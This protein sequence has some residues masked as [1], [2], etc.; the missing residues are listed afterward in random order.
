[1]LN[2]KIYD[3]SSY[4]P[5]ER[6]GTYGG[7][8]GDKEGI[9]IDGEYWIVK[10]PKSTNG[11]VGD[12]PSYTTAPLSEY[13]GSHIYQM[14]GFETHDTLLGIRN[15]KLVVAC[16][17]FC[18]TEGSLREMRTLKNIYNKQL[19]ELLEKSFSSTSSSHLIDIDKMLLV[20]EHNPI[21]QK[22]PEIN[23]RFWDMFIIDILINN[24]DRNNGN[25]GLLLENGQ[26]KLAPV[27]DNGAA[28]SNKMSD[29]KIR[30]LLNDETKIK[31][32]VLNT[33]TLYSHNDKKVNARDIIKLDFVGLKES[34]KRNTPKIQSQMDN[35]QQFISNIPLKFNGISVCSEVRKK[36]YT[37]SM[38]LRLENFLIP[39]FE[40]A[41]EQANEK[42]S[43]IA[44]V[45]K[46]KAEQKNDPQKSFP[47]KSRNNNV[48]IDD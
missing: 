31:N 43:A 1:M 26:Y 18:K 48:D 46:I 27:F 24:N 2:T 15:D 13:I 14:L 12:L 22:V 20:M 30:I 39:A 23:D 4:E 7:Q 3:L 28:F 38:K 17:D 21:L 6:T 9:T 11:M 33:T 40:K 25:W 44:A 34:V 36:F 32:S 5:N 19:S 8:A 45:E 35:I 10:Y 16:K 37:I 41:N 29:E 47:T 42:P